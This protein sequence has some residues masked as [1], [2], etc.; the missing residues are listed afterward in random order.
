MELFVCSY[1][2]TEEGGGELGFLFLSFCFLIGDV[3]GMEAFWDE[4]E[5]KYGSGD[6]L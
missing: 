3:C 6:R 4:Y 5:V 2:N 1:V